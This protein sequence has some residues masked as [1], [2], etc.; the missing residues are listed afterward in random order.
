MPLPLG[1]DI[2]AHCEFHIGAPKH[3]IDNCKAF[4][5]KVY[6]LIDSK[7]VS[8]THVGPNVNNNP[9]LSHA[10]HFVSVIKEFA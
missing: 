7:T 1:Y 3:S 8:F 6:D 10:S 2:N 9:M 4:R 5:Y